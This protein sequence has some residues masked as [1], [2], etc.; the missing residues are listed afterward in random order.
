MV[1]I[2]RRNL[3][4]RAR[5]SGLP[6]YGPVYT[7]PEKPKKTK[8]AKYQAC[9]P[10]PERPHRTARVLRPRQSNSDWLKH[11]PKKTVKTRA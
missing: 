10:A 3:K 2:P 6:R 1:K 8:K 5:K 9:P 7:T 4:L 11:V